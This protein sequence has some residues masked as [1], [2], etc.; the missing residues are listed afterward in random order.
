MYKQDSIWTDLYFVS[1]FLSLFLL[2]AISEGNPH[3]EY[4]RNDHTTFFSLICGNWMIQTGWICH[5]SSGRAR[6]PHSNLGI[7]MFPVTPPCILILCF[8]ICDNSIS[9]RLSNFSLCLFIRG[10]CFVSWMFIESRTIS[11][12]LRLWV[13]YWKG[14][15][16]AARILLTVW[17]SQTLEGWEIDEM[18]SYRESY[19]MSLHLK[20]IKW[21]PHMHFLEYLRLSCVQPFIVMTVERHNPMIIRKST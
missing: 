14:G 8:H 12:Q 21:L 5:S 20:N 18:V 9:S 2:I 19:N 3:W 7:G 16:T 17:P 10:A 13:I 1:G 15:G 4:P 11:C 6:G